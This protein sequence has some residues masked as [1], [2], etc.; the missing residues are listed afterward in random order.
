MEVEAVVLAR[1]PRARARR[2]ASRRGMRR[3]RARLR[4]ARRARAPAEQQPDLVAAEPAPS[5]LGVGVG[6][7]DGE[8]VGIRV[9]GDDE[10]GV[11]RARGLEGEIHR[12][13]LLGVR[14]RDGRERAVGLDLRRHRRRARGSRRPRGRAT[15][16]LPA[17]AVHRGVDPAQALGALGRGSDGGRRGDVR[18]DDRLAARS[19]SRASGAAR[20][21][22]RRR[23]RAG[24][25]RRSR[26]PRA[27]RS[28]T[29]SS[30][31]PR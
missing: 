19:R 14:E 22:R 31:P 26:R 2:P 18:V 9:V 23:R 21:R 20:R 4:A 15:S 1:P 25:A 3:R 12:A 30:A 6:H 27:G 24:C 11:R 28:A 10:L 16:G 8:A 13:R 17:D 5:A 7:R 29:P